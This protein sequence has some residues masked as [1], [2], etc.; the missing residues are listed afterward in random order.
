VNWI[1]FDLGSTLLDESRMIR[2]R[3]EETFA[4]LRGTPNECSAEEFRERMRRA[5]LW[6]PHPYAAAMADMGLGNGDPAWVEWDTTLESP[7]PGARPLLELLHETHS[8]GVIANQ[9]LGAAERLRQWGL[10][11]FFDVIVCSA[12][13]GVEK[14]DLRMFEMALQRAGCAPQS[15]V[16]VGDRLDNDIAPAKRLG[17][18]T[19]WVRQGWGGFGVPTNESAP[20]IIVDSLE[21]LQELAKVCFN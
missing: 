5:A 8:L 10:A 18:R 11:R 15:A 9:S 20:D 2:L 6:H 7:Y 3:V 12:E 13:A 19:V 16:M 4:R 21:E 1:F 17:M 14:P